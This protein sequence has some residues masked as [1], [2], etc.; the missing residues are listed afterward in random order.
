MRTKIHNYSK[1]KITSKKIKSNFF[2]SKRMYDGE[3]LLAGM[4]DVR[5]LARSGSCS[6]FPDYTKVLLPGNNTKSIRD[7]REGDTV[8][9]YNLDE[10]RLTESK[11]MEQIIH[12]DAKVQYFIINGNIKTTAEH[13]FWVNG[14]R[15]TRAHE[16][17]VG[18]WLL[19]P[20]GEKVEISDIESYSA[21]ETVYNL[22]LEG[23]EHNY[24][25]ENVLVHNQR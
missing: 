5:I 25:A 23:E 6:C 13:P 20:T 19:T 15:W 14:E 2:Y 7:I 18:D 21:V 16:I 1:P 9:S 8:T 11:V 10:N 24:F 17:K 3:D 12:L 22:E 4:M